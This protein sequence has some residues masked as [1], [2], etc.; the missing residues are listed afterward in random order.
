[1]S[2]VSGDLSK[3]ESGP[4]LITVGGVSIGHTIDGVKLS[5]KPEV[6]KRTVD[7]YGTHV[8]DLVYVGESIEVTTTIVEKTAANL[9]LVYQWGYETTVTRQA[10]GRV[11]GV[12]G[13]TLAAELVVRP[14]STISDSS[15]DVVFYRVVVASLA[16]VQFGVVTTDRVFGVTFACLVDPTDS[17]ALLGEIRCGASDEP[18]GGLLWS[19]GGRFLL[20]SGDALLLGV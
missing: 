18:T 13:G 16:E 12:R 17:N 7:E 10:W 3:I 11:P 2:Q 19:D 4:C 9:R 20:G 5:I 14:L 15:N 1:V 8:A 6:R